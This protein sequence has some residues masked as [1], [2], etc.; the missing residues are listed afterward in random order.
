MISRT[1]VKYFI[2]ILNP[3]TCQECYASEDAFVFNLHP[4]KGNLFD[5]QGRACSPTPFFGILC[6]RLSA[7]TDYRLLSGVLKILTQRGES[8][9]MHALVN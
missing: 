5:C 1:C 6:V 3:V 8:Q 4:C 7:Q 9:L 2:H